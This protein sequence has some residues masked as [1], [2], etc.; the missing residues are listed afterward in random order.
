ML[1]FVFGAMGKRE[2][3][4]SAFGEGNSLYTGVWYRMYITMESIKSNRPDTLL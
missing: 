2:G 1:S 3:E 4:E